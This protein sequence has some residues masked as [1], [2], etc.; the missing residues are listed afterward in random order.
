MNNPEE[1]SVLY[2][3]MNKFNIKSTIYSPPWKAYTIYVFSQGKLDVF[4]LDVDN[5]KIV[6][7]Y[8]FDGHKPC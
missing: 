3:L 1:N 8:G 6:E 5:Q 4:H 2:K 7:G